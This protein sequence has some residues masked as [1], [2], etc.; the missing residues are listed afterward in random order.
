MGSADPPFGLNSSDAVLKVSTS[1]EPVTAAEPLLKQEN[2][3]MKR[4][5]IKSWII[6]ALLFLAFGTA[7]GGSLVLDNADVIAFWS[8]V[9]N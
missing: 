9:L 2:K 3:S 7:F 6:N 4:Q 5:I 8:S 1:L